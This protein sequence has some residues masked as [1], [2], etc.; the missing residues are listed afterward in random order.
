MSKREE[1]AAELTAEA[2]RQLSEGIA[3]WRKPWGAGKAVLPT[4][5]AT[6]KPY[7]GINAIMLTLLAQDRPGPNLWA[8]YKQ[9]QALGGQVRK[10]EKATRAVLWS[11]VE[12]VE[13]DGTIKESYYM[14]Y[15]SLFHVSQIDGIE[16]PKKWTGERA[17]VEVAPALEAIVEGYK[18]GP[19]IVHK[20]SDSAHYTP[21]ND[22]V[23]MPELSQFATPEGYAE[24]LLHELTHS[25]GHKSRLGRFEEAC[26]PV[27]F[28]SPVYAKEEL[29]A[30]IGAWILSAHAGISLP[31]EQAGSYLAG[32][33]KAL[34]NDPAMLVWASQKAQKAVDRILGTEFGEEGAE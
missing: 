22:V 11:P 34:D 31:N 26:A 5:L 8:T 17:E 21:S 32:W 24:T 27:R 2:V 18:N 3:P 29:V 25:T 20:P 6:G 16:L 10:G 15:F 12:K 13:A 9:A 33:L 1:I 28:G 4:S 30:E 7:R 14:R 23:T 19:E